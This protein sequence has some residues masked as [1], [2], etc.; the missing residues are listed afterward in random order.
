MSKAK[1]L[2]I[3]WAGTKISNQAIKI[4]N[5]IIQNEAINFKGRGM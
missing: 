4:I 3:A 5:V 1:N 2:I